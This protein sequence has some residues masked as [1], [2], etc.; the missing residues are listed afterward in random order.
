MS[1]S[2][3]EMIRNNAEITLQDFSIKKLSKK[4]VSIF[5]GDK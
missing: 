2:E 4:L 1:E 5:E 3:L